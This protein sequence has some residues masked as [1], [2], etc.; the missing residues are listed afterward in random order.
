M[1]P[2]KQTTE[3]KLLILVSFFSGEGTPYTDT[4]YH[5]HILMEVCH[6]AVFY[7]PPCFFMCMLLGQWTLLCVKYLQMSCPSV[8]LKLRPPM[9]HPPVVEDDT[10]SLLQPIGHLWNLTNW[11][12]FDF[13]ITYIL[14]STQHKVACNGHNHQ[15][16]KDQLSYQSFLQAKN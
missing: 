7:R 6:S 1:C 9:K 2:R 14:Q 15:R 5:T 16:V 12:P 11:V 13:G 8:L 3:P 10:V 4:S